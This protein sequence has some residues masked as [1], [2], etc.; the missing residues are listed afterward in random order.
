MRTRHR[1]GEIDCVENRFRGS[2]HSINRV[3]NRY[4]VVP[5]ADV[6]AALDER[7]GVERHRVLVNMAGPASHLG[8]EYY[9][10]EVSLRQALIK[11]WSTGWMANAQRRSRRCYSPA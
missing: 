4:R 3:S 6:G 5:G 8:V 1:E 7:S 2:G 10:D 11:Q 9:G